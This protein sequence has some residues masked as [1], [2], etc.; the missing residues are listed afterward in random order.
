MITITIRTENAA[1]QSSDYG[2]EIARLLH[3]V[4][5]AYEVDGGPYRFARLFDSNGN[6]VGEVKLTGK[7]RRL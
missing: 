4:A 3:Q 7:D 2:P 5:D 1:F 6:T